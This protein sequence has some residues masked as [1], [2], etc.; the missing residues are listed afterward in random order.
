MKSPPWRAHGGDE[1]VGDVAFVE[2]VVG[3][4]DGFFAALAV[5]QGVALGLDELAQCRG[6]VGLAEDLT[7]QRPFVRRT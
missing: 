4:V 3:G 7:G 5:L 2:A 1:L 6:E